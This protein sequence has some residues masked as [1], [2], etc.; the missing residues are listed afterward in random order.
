MI[1]PTKKMQRHWMQCLPTVSRCHQQETIARPYPLWRVLWEYS[2][3]NG[4]L[5]D[6]THKCM[7]HHR[8]LRPCHPSSPGCVSRKVANRLHEENCPSCPTKQRRIKVTGG[9][10]DVFVVSQRHYWHVCYQ[11][12]SKTQ[13]K[14]KTSA[15]FKHSIPHT[16]LPKG[17]PSSHTL[18]SYTK[19]ML[20]M[21]ERNAVY[22]SSPPYH[23]AETEH[24]ECKTINKNKSIRK[25]QCMFDRLR[26]RNVESFFS[27]VLNFLCL[28]LKE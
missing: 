20:S 19:S 11:S 9:A 23:P 26:I 15:K 13:S 6:R 8:Y 25:L 7:H 27:P 2:A 1:Y 24:R 14:E 3:Q 28:F 18:L 4:Y 10:I 16:W 17:L 21:L 22:Q 12:K 5:E